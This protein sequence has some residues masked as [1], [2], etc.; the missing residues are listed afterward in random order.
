MQI[1]NQRIITDVIVIVG[2]TA[3][4]K[5]SVAFELSGSIGGEIISAD[6]MA[7]YK[8]MD[9][10]TAKPTPEEQHRAAFHCIN[11]ADPALSYSVGDFQKSAQCAIDDII[12]RNPPA[13]VVGGSGLYIRAAVDGL[14]DIIP[15]GDQDFRQ[16]LDIIA[17]SEGVNK[18]HEMLAE[19]D[20]VSAER[21]HANNLKRVIR[22]LEIHHST[23]CKPSELFEAGSLRNARYPQALFFGLSM[24]REKLYA[25]IECRVDDMIREGLIDEVRSLMEKVTDPD[26]TAMQG[27]G[28]KEIA[29]YL[30]GEFG[31][32]EAI[33][34]L[35]KNTRRFAKRQ[36][37]WFNAD[38]R[39]RWIDVEGRSAVEVSNQI[40]ELLLV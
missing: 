31:L 24:P 33:D 25:R 11:I 6:S 2:P 40:K 13:I 27:L 35:K 32:K 37:T 3:V 23:G 14:D 34:L 22:A 39:I 26:C 38:K 7:V 10:G 17:Q 29:A 15:A 1:D 20:P 9:I 16:K 36:Y 4:G 28:Y 5:T 19:I 12:K 21:I 18:V 8:Y 30:R